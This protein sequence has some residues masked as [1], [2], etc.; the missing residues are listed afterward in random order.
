MMLSSAAKFRFTPYGSSP[1]GFTGGLLDS[2]RFVHCGPHMR[3]QAFLDV[4]LHYDVSDARRGRV[5][6][7]AFVNG[8]END[9]RG[10]LSIAQMAD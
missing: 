8:D 10:N 5:R 6:D 3:N 2:R 7:Y 1:K 9:R 4:G